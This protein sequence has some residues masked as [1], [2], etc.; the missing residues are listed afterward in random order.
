MSFIFQSQAKVRSAC[1]ETRNLNQAIYNFTHLHT[2][3]FSKILSV[4]NIS[5]LKRTDSTERIS[6]PS[7]HVAHTAFPNIALRAIRLSQGTTKD[8]SFK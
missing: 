2:G 1:D 8:I 7:P 6:L 4:K 5:Y 3:H